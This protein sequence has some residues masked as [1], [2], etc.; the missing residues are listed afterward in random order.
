MNPNH[1]RLRLSRRHEQSSARRIDAQVDEHDNPQ[2][3][4]GLAASLHTLVTVLGPTTVLTALLVYFGYVGTRAR[5]EYFGIYLSMVDL[6]TR[7]L[8][9][10]GLEVVYLPALVIF[11]SALIACGAH[12]AV[13]WLLTSQARKPAWTVVALVAVVGVLLI[14]RALVGI[15]VPGAANTETTPGQTPLALAFGPVLVTYSM[16]ITMRLRMARES[17]SAKFSMF[18]QWYGT[19]TMQILRRAGLASVLGIFIVGLFWASNSFALIFGAG[20]AYQD[21]LI[22]QEKP[23]VIL[24]MPERLQTVPP[25]VT[26]ID[27]GQN[28]EEGFRYRYR[29]LR[30][31]IE[32]GGRL[33]LIPAYWTRAG[34]TI[35]VPYDS[36]VRIQLI[37]SSTVYESP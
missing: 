24:D 21:A 12:A 5:F 27:L 4:G 9:L 17:K 7:E 2:T 33:F 14:G 23:E 34:R 16:W 35:I 29:N 8:T 6:S 1:P 37:P 20:R 25:G 19:S 32:S 26:E 13:L 15:L 3:G 18:T 10:F 31:L 22:F 28:N 11:L 36:D 30:L